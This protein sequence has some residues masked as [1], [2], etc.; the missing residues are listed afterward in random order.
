MAVVRWRPGS[1]PKTTAASPRT[2]ENTGSYLWEPPADIVENVDNYEIN[3]E[4]PGIQREDVK[5]NLV[6]NTLT[7]R[8]EKKQT[9]KIDE[10]KYYR[11]ERRFGNFQRTFQLP[12]E[13][14]AAKVSATFKDG[15]LTITLIKKEE[16]KPRE[17]SIQ[18]G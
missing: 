14:D 5:I 18:I 11:I 17:I 10:K 12:T 1:M 8:G 16:T 3:L 4:L 6:E 13:V 7:V 9:E 2:W 15:M